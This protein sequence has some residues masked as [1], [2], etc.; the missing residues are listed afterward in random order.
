MN[1]DQTIAVRRDTGTTVEPDADE[2]LLTL[3]TLKDLT[4]LGR[5]AGGVKGGVTTKGRQCE[6]GTM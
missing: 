2:L 1:R 6:C 5:E 4:V 3:E